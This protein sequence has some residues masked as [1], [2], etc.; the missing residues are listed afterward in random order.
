MGVDYNLS[1]CSGLRSHGFYTASI[2]RVDQGTI[3]INDRDEDVAAHEAVDEVDT[4]GCFF[5]KDAFQKEVERS[6]PKRHRHR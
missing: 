4:A 5:Y 1:T 2:E 6:R 3:Y